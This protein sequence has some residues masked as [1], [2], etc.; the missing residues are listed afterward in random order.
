MPRRSRRARRSGNPVATA[1]S[2]VTFPLRVRSR[3]EAFL[4]PGAR[5]VGALGVAM[6][7]ACA[8]CAGTP[9]E[10]RPPWAGADLLPVWWMVSLAA[11]S[12][13]G[14]TFV[15]DGQTRIRRAIGR[16]AALA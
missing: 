9:P 13:L 15:H 11:A 14:W 10:R 8:I 16:P 1:A 2:A 4:R 6:L 7:A 12:L 3:V 5:V